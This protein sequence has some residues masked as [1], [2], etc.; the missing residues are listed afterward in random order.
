MQLHW[1]PKKRRSRINTPQHLFSGMSSSISIAKKKHYAFSLDI[2]P[3]CFFAFW[4]DLPVIRHTAEWSGTG[5]FKC[6]RFIGSRERKVSLYAFRN[7]M[8]YKRHDTNLVY[9]IFFIPL[10]F[11]DYW[12]H[13]L[14]LAALFSISGCSVNVPI[15]WDIS[16]TQPPKICESAIKNFHL[17]IIEDVGNSGTESF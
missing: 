3:E 4:C 14:K 16:F 7:A 15:F 17:C 5:C 8:H 10:I 6:I 12:L 9:V 11:N 2:L 1:Y 13:F